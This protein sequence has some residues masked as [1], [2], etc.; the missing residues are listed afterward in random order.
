MKF[1]LLH[2]LGEVFTFI[3]KVFICG[4]S[5]IIGYILVSRDST[6]ESQINSKLFVVIIFSIIGYLIA[7][8]FYM[9]YGIAADAIILCFFKDKDLADK[10]GRAPIAPEP[11][12]DFYEKFKK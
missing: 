5:G 6:L 12:K 1:G 3:G 2:L 10:T 9:V 8:L 7:S 4:S 11:M